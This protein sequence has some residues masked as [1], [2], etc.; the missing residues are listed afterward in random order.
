MATNKSPAE[1]GKTYPNLPDKIKNQGSGFANIRVFSSFSNYEGINDAFLGFSNA[2][3]QNWGRPLVQAGLAYAIRHDA[4]RG[5]S[6]GSM[7]VNSSNEIIALHNAD[8]SESDVGLSVALKSERFLYNNV[9]NYY[10]PEYDLIYGGG[11]DQK[12]S[13]K[14]ALMKAYAA[15]GGIKTYLFPGDSKK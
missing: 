3:L 7:V 14:Q 12:S 10:V 15:R 8:W 4:M 2:Q 6:S 11:Q 5:G 9:Q 13:Y 1:N